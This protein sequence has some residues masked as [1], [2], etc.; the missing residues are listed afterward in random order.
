MISFFSF[1]WKCAS[2]GISGLERADFE[3]QINSN[4][5]NRTWK[6]IKRDS[7]KTKIYLVI[8]LLSDEVFIRCSNGQSLIN[9]QNQV[10]SGCNENGR[11]FAPMQKVIEQN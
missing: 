1:E 10:E 2:E 9:P 6:S 5:M 4:Q 11:S 3:L 7:N 8:A